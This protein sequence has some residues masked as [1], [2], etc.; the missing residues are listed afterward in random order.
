LTRRPADPEHRSVDRFGRYTVFECLG[1]GGMATVHRATVEIGGGVVREVALKRMLPNLADDK[2]TLDDFIRE[3]KLAAQLQHPNIVRMLE[4]GRQGTTYFIAMELVKG[5]SLL[6]LMKLMHSRRQVTP[7]GVVIALL[8]E[9]CEALDYAS[10]MTD[11]EGEPMEIVH[12]DLSPSNLIIADDGHLKIIDFGVAKSVSGKFMTSSGLVKGKLGYMAIESLAGKQ[13]DKRADIFSIGV[14]AWELLTGQR[15]F[16]GLNEYEVIMKIR[17]GAKHPP[18]RV[19]REVSPELDEIVMHALSRRRN[20][21][22]PSA[23]VMKRALDTLRRT[24]REGPRDVD[25]WRRSLLPQVPGEDTTTME[26]ASIAEMLV[27]DSEQSVTRTALRRRQDVMIAVE[28]QDPTVMTE[29]PS[30]DVLTDPAAAAIP[31]EIIAAVADL[32]QP[33]ETHQAVIVEQLV[34][35]EPD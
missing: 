13:V 31:S 15:L 30:Q 11:S 9:L 16:T 17:A 5:E 8:C 25:A 4:L 18:S 6:Q 7:P 27:R 24:Y 10:T 32:S 14:V 22:W 33:T 34:P 3:A 21:R 19:N 28:E 12:R 1:A 20:E 23:A 35:Q 2:K 26:I 29:R